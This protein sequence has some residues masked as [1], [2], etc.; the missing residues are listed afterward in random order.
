MPQQLIPTISSV[1]IA[2]SDIEIYTEYV[3][4]NGEPFALRAFIS[5]R[6]FRSNYSIKWRTIR[7]L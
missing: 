3:Q 1:S 2:G 6:V 4:D 5:N 7:F